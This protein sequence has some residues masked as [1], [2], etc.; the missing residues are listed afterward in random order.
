MKNLK[1]S[2]VAGLTLGAVAASASAG[3]TVFQLFDHPDGTDNPPPYGLRMD[4]L[5]DGMSGATGGVTSFSF[6]HFGDVLMT[7]ND[8]GSTITINIAGTVYGGE[9]VG[10]TYG[11]GEGAYEID[12]TYNFNVQAQGTGYVVQPSN[13]G[14]VGSITSLGNIDVPMGT[15]RNFYDFSG[16][17]FLFLQ[18]EHRLA[19]HSQAGQGFWVGRGWHTMFAD[20]RDTAGTQDWLFLGQMIPTPSAV[21]FGAF[22]LAGVAGTSRRRRV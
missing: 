18:D 8:N 9:D 11:F 5:F 15:S 1:N 10:A 13:S 14:N 12:F 17:S 3:T 16:N 7:V 20:G 6:D 19:G 22:G 2:I 4:G 21:A